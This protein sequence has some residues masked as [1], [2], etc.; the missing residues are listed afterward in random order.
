MS[1]RG[2]S[3]LVTGGSRGIGRYATGVVPSTSATV[4]AVVRCT[5][6]TNP[7]WFRKMSSAASATSRES[8]HRTANERSRW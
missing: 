4:D 1:F 5:E 7:S 6:Y 2:A 3:V 8:L